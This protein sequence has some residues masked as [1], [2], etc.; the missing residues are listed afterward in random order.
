MFGRAERDST[1]EADVGAAA[2][3]GHPREL[4]CACSKFFE[5]HAAVAALG[6]KS[7]WQSGLHRTV[8]HHVRGVT[9]A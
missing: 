4:E 8:G 3:G 1:V 2:D 9:P 5:A 6:R 7:S